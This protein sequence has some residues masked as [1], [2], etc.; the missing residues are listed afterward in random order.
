[1]RFVRPAAIV[2]ALLAMCSAPFAPA[3][4][5]GVPVFAGKPLTLLEERGML[6]SAQDAME[7][8]AFHPF[9]PSPNYIA[10]A[11]LPAAHGDDKDVPQN[12]GIGFE[13]VTAGV[14]YVLSEWPVFPTSL[15]QYPSVPAMG[16]CTT[17]HLNLGTPRHPRAYSWTTPTLVFA[18]QADVDPGVNPNPRALRAEWARLVR[19][20]ACR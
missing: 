17:G 19:R 8:V 9:V 4:A 1:M 16:T 15:S 10:V 13:Y 6:M 14:A 2:T 12:R 5:Q 20:G 3:F 11:L 18:L 7:R